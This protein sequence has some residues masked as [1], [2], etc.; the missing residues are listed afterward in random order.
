MK[1]ID[2]IMRHW[3][4]MGLIF[5]L[6]GCW[7]VI[8]CGTPQDD[9]ENPTPAPPPE[10]GETSASAGTDFPFPEGVVAIVNGVT[11]SE[12]DLARRLNA[13]SWRQ[14]SLHN[15]ASV[16]D[17]AALTTLRKDALEELVEEALLEQFAR[18]ERIEV[19]E[20][21]LQQ[22]IAEIQAEY[23][24]QEIRVILENLGESYEAWLQAQRQAL[25]L[26]KVV[27][28]HL[29]SFLTITDEDARLY[30]EEH[31]GLYDHP[32][33]VRASQILTYDKTVARQALLALQDGVDFAE[34]ARLYSESSDAERGGDLGFFEPGRMPPEFEAA[35]FALR[36]GEISE[37]VKTPYGYQIFMLTGQRAAERFSFD[38]V[39]DRI[40]TMLRRQKRIAAVDL[41]LSELQKN[42]Q[43]LVNHEGLQSVK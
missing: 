26:D 4:F 19:S 41:W 1:Q 14:V 6:V 10:T 30:Y 37:I 12:E 18:Q 21:E 15:Y 35:I 25:L 5:G 33:Q 8:A 23:Q 39:K 9:L 36:M 29:G 32:A 13:P 17:A 40:L 20:A 27:Q 11:I 7:L 22:R 28:I 2:R 16:N 24:G 34:V 3:M 31:Q 38:E 42:A 43:I